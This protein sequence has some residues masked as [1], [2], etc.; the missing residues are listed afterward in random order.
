MSS[1]K[2]KNA[3]P[4]HGI[5]IQPEWEKLK[6]QGWRFVYDS[7]TRFL[8]CEHENGKGKFSIARFELQSDDRETLAHQIGY[9]I[10]TFLND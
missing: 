9:T 10:A 4:V 6:G 7:S 1:E 5:V 2:A 8:G 3:A